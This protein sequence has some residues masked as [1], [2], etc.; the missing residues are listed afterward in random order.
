MSNS[1]FA[2]SDPYYGSQWYLNEVR[3]TEAWSTSRSAAV[4]VALLILE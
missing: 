4:I 2:A 1:G 3:A